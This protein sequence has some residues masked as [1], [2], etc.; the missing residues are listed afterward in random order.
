MRNQY[1]VDN[2]YLWTERLY[3][4]IWM[5]TQHIIHENVQINSNLW[6]NFNGLAL[7]VIYILTQMNS[8]G[9]G[10]FREF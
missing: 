2:S 7:D 4:F 10:N 5:L 9:G 8:S 6:W 1:T 3:S